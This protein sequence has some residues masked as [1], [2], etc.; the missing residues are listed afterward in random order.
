MEGIGSAL[1]I[2]ASCGSIS[3]S[4][5]FSALALVASNALPVL[6]TALTSHGEFE[7]FFLPAQ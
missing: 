2:F 5:Y 7:R 6:A 3:M 1:L 4:R